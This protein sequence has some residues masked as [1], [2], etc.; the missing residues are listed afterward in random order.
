MQEQSLFTNQPQ[1]ITLSQYNARITQAING[2]PALQNQWVIAETSDLRV[3]RGHCYMELVEKDD[4]GTTV[5]KLSAAIWA[6]NF[7]RL[8]AKFK[9]ATGADLKTGMKVLVLATKLWPMVRF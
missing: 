2:N 7:N 5:A 3:V 1:G 4:H 6:S 9:A 8:N